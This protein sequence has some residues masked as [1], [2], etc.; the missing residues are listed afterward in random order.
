METGTEMQL[1]TPCRTHLFDTLLD[2]ETIH[3]LDF[4]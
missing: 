1:N 2:R 4:D 3:P